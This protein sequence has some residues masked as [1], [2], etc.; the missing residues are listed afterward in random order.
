VNFLELQ[1]EVL[2]R[3]NESMTTPVFWKYADIQD[4]L[5]E[6][7]QQLAEAT[8]LYEVTFD[9]IIDRDEAVDDGSQM[10]YDL[11]MILE[12]DFLALRRVQNVSTD[13]WMNTVSV[14][15]LDTTYRQWEQVVNTPEYIIQRGLSIVG[16]FPIARSGDEIHFVFAAIPPI[17]GDDAEYVRAGEEFIE[18]LIEYALYYMYTTEREYDKAMSAYQRYL[19][20][21]DKL[22]GETGN[23]MSNDA[24]RRMGGSDVV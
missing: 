17:L 19:T 18:A 3:L 21:E 24:N 8:E 7:Y 15:D 6:G 1:Q 20:F 23:R 12:N 13:R 11:S 22:R 9:K 10:Y 2:G 14:R 4:G 5:N 16:F